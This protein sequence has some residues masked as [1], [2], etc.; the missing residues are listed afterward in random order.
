MAASSIPKSVS[1]IGPKT[2]ERCRLI[3]N[4]FEEAYPGEP[5]AALDFVDPF[6]CIC[7]VALSAQTTDN[8][9]NRVTPVLFAA[10]PNSFALAQASQTDV[11]EII[12]SLG[13]F[14]NK[15][16][17]LIN[18]AQMLVADFGGEVPSTMEELIKLPGVARKTAN[19]VLSESFGIVEGIAVDTHVFRVSHRLGIS[20]AKT[21]ELTEGDLCKAFPRQRWHRV[22]FEMITFGR[23]VCDARRPLC[24]ECFLCDLCPSCGRAVQ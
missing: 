21:P 9:V 11:E 19:I 5:K 1:R 3:A 2:I 7:A 17:N 24:S 6:Q 18:M 15:A 13:F 20:S 10:Y 4:R 8:N 22:N 16:K 14:R 23:T 12:H